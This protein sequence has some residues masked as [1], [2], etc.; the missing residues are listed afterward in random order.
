MDVQFRNLSS[1]VRNRWNQAFDAPKPLPYDDTKWLPQPSQV[2]R[3]L[4]E[5]ILKNNEALQSELLGSPPW[6]LAAAIV[7]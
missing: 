3:M 1:S 2:M 4:I 7:P 6:P 5:Y